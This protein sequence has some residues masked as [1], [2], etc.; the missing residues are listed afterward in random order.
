M[1]VISATID[2][3]EKK[4][5]SSNEKDRKAFSTLMKM[6]TKDD[7]QYILEALERRGHDVYKSWFSD[8]AGNTIDTEDDEL[9]MM[10]RYFEVNDR[11]KHRQF[12]IWFKACD[13]NMRNIVINKL[14][15]RGH[16]I[17]KSWFAESIKRCDIKIDGI[18]T[19]P[20]ADRH[21]D[22][23]AFYLPKHIYTNAKLCAEAAGISV[24][25][26]VSEAVAV[27]V[28]VIS[29]RKSIKGM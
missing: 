17:S 27:Y 24:S 14:Q 2:S 8:K 6:Y 25:D 9:D 15:E 23:N 5:I 3:M 12:T 16:D 10:I 4:F 1:A 29:G 22:D 21:V 18:N 7:Q 26:L 20:R 13:S 28:A 11:V 19:Q